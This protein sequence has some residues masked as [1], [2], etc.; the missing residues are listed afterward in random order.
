MFHMVWALYGIVMI[1]TLMLML[2]VETER[3]VQ[4]NGRE[5]Q[6]PR[7]LR[8]DRVSLRMMVASVN[9]IAAAAFLMWPL[10]PF[11]E[12]RAA[13]F[14]VLFLGTGLGV[15]PITCWLVRALDAAS[16]RPAGGPD[17]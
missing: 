14:V 2:P 6:V 4:P 15:A 10:T 8:A 12:G 5:L 3:K 16:R 7:V 9:L 11:G 13:Y 17:E 1:G